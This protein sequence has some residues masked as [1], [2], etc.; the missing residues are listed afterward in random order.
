MKYFC[1]VML[2][3][4]YTSA[5]RTCTHMYVSEKWQRP[6][7]LFLCA[8]LFHPMMLDVRWNLHPRSDQIAAGGGRTHMWV[9]V[10]TRR[11]LLIVSELFIRI[12]Q[13]RRF[14][15]L[16][17]FIVFAAHFK[18]NSVKIKLAFAGQM[19]TNVQWE[20]LA[21][22]GRANINACSQLA[23]VTSRRGLNKLTDDP[24]SHECQ[25]AR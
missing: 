6:N 24:N 11:Y 15:T 17:S 4:E 9:Q 20:T 10:P 5:L 18:L 2:I 3:P 8:R 12:Y 21:S 16:I 25:A 22:K 13:L 1:A 14:K 23:N 19:E 7:S